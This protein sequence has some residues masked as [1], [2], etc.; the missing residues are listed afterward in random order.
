MNPETSGSA[1]ATVEAGSEHIDFRALFEA[2]PGLYLVLDTG[3]RIVAASD[4]YLAA[5]MTQRSQII[6]RNLFDVFPDNPDDPGATGTSNLRASLDRV[7]RHGRSD[8]MAVQKYDIRRPEED[9]GGYEERYWSPVN[10]PVFD[11]GQRLVYILHR[12]E[13]VTE[14]VHLRE[15]G[16]KHEAQ[17]SE[18]RERTERM[19]AEIIRRSQELQKAN[20][21]LTSAN[22]AKSD[23][24]SRMSHELRTP[25]TAV[26][27]FGELLQLADIAEEQREWVGSIL[28][29][30]NH[31][32]NLIN[33]I[34]DLSRIEAGQMSMSMEPVPVKQLLDDTLALMRPL[35]ASRNVT[36]GPPN[37][38]A[39]GGYVMADHQRLKQVLINLVSN[40]IK[41]NREGGDV[42]IDVERSGDERLLIKVSDTG[43]GI[44]AANLKR[45]FVPFERLG[46]E[47]TGVDGTGLGLALSRDIV[48]A[49]QGVMDVASTPG[50]GTSFWV[51]LPCAET[52][53]VAEISQAD[54][55]LLT[56]REYSGTRTLLYIE[57]TLANVRLIE[58]I[59]GRRPSIK[60]I[61]AMQGQ[62][63]LDIAR[64]HHPDLILLDLHLP[65]VGGAE[66]LSRLQA[67]DDTRDIPVVILSANATKQ[68]PE[69]FLSRGAC[70]YLTKPIA[71]RRLLEVLDSQLG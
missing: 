48:V 11:R 33:D 68:H 64:E 26:L 29:A 3:L 1:G 8:P 2:A 13:D 23:F 27:G 63:G 14:F 39:G 43:L 69:E 22:M 70:A 50:A 6:G 67:S 45:L 19:Q 17:T 55:A 10:S 20:K 49:M 40:A 24:L 57:D 35:A 60:L 28:K 54:E 31:L 42:R 16:T 52:S 38:I 32:L 71:M 21:E 41:Y 9:G 66:V 47:A 25:L 56:V 62:L 34:L 51:E 4:A 30:G 37:M 65:D 58:A 44:N 12:V 15:W 36:I 46:A 59:L 61:P 18:L 53:A 7:I 5:T